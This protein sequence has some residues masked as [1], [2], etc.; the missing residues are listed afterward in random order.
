MKMKKGKN[1]KKFAGLIAFLGLILFLFALSSCEIVFALNFSEDTADI[2]DTAISFGGLNYA[3]TGE[4]ADK[5]VKPVKTDENYS[6]NYDE[7]GKPAL[8]R[9]N[10]FEVE[11]EVEPVYAGADIYDI[12]PKYDAY[13]KINRDAVGY[14]KIEGTAIEFPVVFN[15]DNDYYLSHDIYKNENRHGTVFMDASNRGA[16]LDRNTLLHGHNFMD[17]KIFSDLEKYKNKEFF[18]ANKTVIF[19]NLYSDMEW[20]VFAFYVVTAEDYYLKIWFE[21]SEDDKDYRDFVDLIKSRAVIWR[22]YDPQPGDYMLTLHTCSLEFKDCHILI[23]AKLVKKTDNL[24][25]RR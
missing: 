21:E 24:Q 6:G 1:M 11:V 7:N 25:I 19:N 12:N 3:E 4:T 2:T 5:K 23:H 10:N 22:D 17:G 9:L 14:I 15:G 20:E 8:N 16:V 18:D 13:L